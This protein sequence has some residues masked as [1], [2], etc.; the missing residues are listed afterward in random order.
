MPAPVWCWL[1]LSAPATRAS[2]LGMNMPCS[3]LRA[4]A[5]C[6]SCAQEVSGSLA[7]AWKGSIR[8]AVLHKQC[9]SSM[10]AALHRRFRGTSTTQ[11]VCRA[12]V[13][14]KRCQGSMAAAPHRGSV[15]AVSQRRCWVAQGR[16]RQ[17]AASAG[18][19]H[20]HRNVTLN[21]RNRRLWEGDFHRVLTGS[22]QW[23]GVIWSRP[24][25]F[26]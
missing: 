21:S 17:V 10:A 1:S 20:H 7:A 19:L 14:H 23:A 16:L 15:A 4:P 26:T 12:A 13:S 3:T 8:A 11:G 25:A 6:S 22:D 9:Q 18:M 2:Q 24:L 5:P